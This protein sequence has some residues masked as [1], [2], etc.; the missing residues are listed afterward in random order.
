MYLD[1]TAFEGWACLHLV[2]TAFEERRW[3]YLVQA[4]LRFSN[5]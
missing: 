2:R 5:N 3:V 4:Y 1:R